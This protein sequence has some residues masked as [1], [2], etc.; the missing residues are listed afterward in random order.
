MITNCI[1]CVEY[2]CIII[3]HIDIL[4]IK[5]IINNLEN[6][7]IKLINVS[8]HS[9]NSI[10]PHEKAIEEIDNF[11]SHFKLIINIHQV[12]SKIHLF[13]TLIKQ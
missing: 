10:K 2:E 6:Q 12:I 4:L 9:I 8:D 11:C 1:F 5:S 3:E 7:K 13:L